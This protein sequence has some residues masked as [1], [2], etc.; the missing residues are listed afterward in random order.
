ML[1]L[2]YGQASYCLSCMPS[3]G[4]QHSSPFQLLDPHFQPWS[5]LVQAAPFLPSQWELS[6]PLQVRP[7]SAVLWGRCAHQQL[8]CCLWVVLPRTNIRNLSE[9]SRALLAGS[10]RASVSPWDS[11]AAKFPCINFQLR[12]SNYG[13]LPGDGLINY[14]NLSAC[15]HWNKP[16]LSL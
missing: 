5:L 12:K 2:M 1:L 10:S 13:K 4:G 3:S 6:S 15:P 11:G 16:L 8:F 14:G 7:F 9:V